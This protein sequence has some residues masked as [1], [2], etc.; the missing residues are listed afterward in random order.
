MTY[1]ANNE[2]VFS[3]AQSGAVAG[4]FAGSPITSPDPSSYIAQSIAAFEFAVEFD[5]QWGDTAINELIVFNI[6]QQCASYWDKRPI[7]S[8]VADS[9]SVD[10][11]AIIALVTAN[12]A[13]SIAGGVTPRA[14]GAGGGGDV[15]EVS[16]TAPLTSSGGD[17][18]DISIEAGSTIGDVMVWNGTDWVIAQLTADQIL[19]GFSIESFTV[20][21]GTVEVGATVTN[22]TVTASYSAEPA[23]ASV[24]NTAS[25][26]SPLALVAPYTG[27]TVTGAF[28][29]ATATA[30]DFTLTAISTGGVTKTASAAITWEFRSFA[31]AGAAGA[32]SA[33]ASGTSAVLNGGAGTIASAGLFGS[34]VG[35]TFNVTL[36]SDNAYIL[37]PHTATPHTFTAGGF[38][39]PVNA[40]T[41]FSFTNQEGVASSYDL[42]QSTNVLSGS[43]AIVCAS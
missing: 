34:I 33:T 35:Q 41:T 38:A 2:D 12:N 22:P 17:T 43:V 13:T 37:T 18:P 21:G 26:D 16:A 36:S 23:S 30:V 42:Y 20:S 5:T 1:T 31:G 39:F 27:G 24:T 14:W 19:P 11:A 3:A 7:T 9:Y 32:T 8:D 10:V 4:S 28:T 25:I 6:F 29:E 15:T 40:P